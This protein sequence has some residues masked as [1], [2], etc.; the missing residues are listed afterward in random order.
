MNELVV[1]AFV[2][3]PV[4]SLAA[5]ASS[6]TS[7][8][9]ATICVAIEAPVYWLTIAALFAPVALLTSTSCPFTDTL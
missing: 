1:V 5:M 6:I 9:D 4:E 2:E 7:V 8:V 3:F